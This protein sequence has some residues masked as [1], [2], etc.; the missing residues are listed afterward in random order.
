MHRA[1]ITKEAENNM[2]TQTNKTTET[3]N[4]MTYPECW[5]VAIL[6]KY[7]PM[8][9]AAM[10]PKFAQ[11]LRDHKQYATKEHLPDV[12]VA[13]LEK[14]VLAVSGDSVENSTIFALTELGEDIYKKLY[15]KEP[16]LQA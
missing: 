1:N 13:L 11:A 8:T 5:T 10:S 16:V 6:G 7:G 15:H 14:E 12:L 4:E 2:D 9:R 3:Y